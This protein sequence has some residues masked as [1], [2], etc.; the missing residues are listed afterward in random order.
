MQSHS[1]VT[2]APF[3]PRACDRA[4]G[5]VAVALLRNGDH[6]NTTRIDPDWAP[7]SQYWKGAAGKSGSRI[8]ASQRSAPELNA[9]S[10]ELDDR[11]LSQPRSRS[12]PK[13]T[14]KKEVDSSFDLWENV[15]SA[16]PGLLY[17]EPVFNRLPSNPVVLGDAQHREY[18]KRVVCESTPQ[19]MREVESI[20]RF[21]G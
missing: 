17:A 16:E 14:V 7:E 2:V 20:T 4:L 12:R 15:A 6:V 5:P 13:G 19:S 1:I 10:D 21:R 18:K 11:C 9:I 3:S 8:M